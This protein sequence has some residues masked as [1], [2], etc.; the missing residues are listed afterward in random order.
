MSA[1][2]YFP[3]LLFASLALLTAAATAQSDFAVVLLPDTQ[4][5]SESYANVFNGQTQWIVA[6]A[7]A[8]K[9]QMVLGLGDVVNTPGQT[10]EWQNADAAIRVLENAGIPTYIAIGN[11]DYANANAST[12]SATTFNQYFGPARY[13]GKSWY[14]G[15]YPAGSNENFYG[16]LTLG[17]EAYLVLVL[18]YV[19]RTAALN[20]AKTVLDA[21]SGKKVIV[22]EH[23]F[24]HS[25]GTRTDVCD[26]GDMNSDNNGE[27]QWMSLLRNY[28]NIVM[29]VNG[30][31]T[32]GGGHGWRKDLGVKGNIVNQM[33]SDYQDYPNGGDGWLRILK[34]HPLSKQIS[35][36]TYSPFLNSNMTG[37]LDQ[38]TLNYGTPAPV[39]GTATVSGRVR[40]A[41]IGSTQDCQPV[42]AATVTTSGVTKLTDTNGAY[43]MSL[44][45]P[46]SY[47]VSSYLS[48]WNVQT[49]TVNAWTN[50]PAD[51]EFFLTPKRGT[52]A[53]FVKNTSGAGVA[54]A[55][56]N[57]TGGMVN[58]NRTVKTDST[59]HYTTGL[60]S[61]GNYTATA[62]MTGH[63]TQK[64][65]TSVANN[66]TTT[67][68][69]SNF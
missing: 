67:L 3:A 40:M 4:N 63:T 29:V 65:A 1:R 61:I 41:R 30:H 54:G 69:F 21:S 6:N 13:S 20:W 50:Y 59:G 39:S 19:P 26:T 11:H 38:F 34:F 46:A 56:I 16:S 35:V 62:S 33:L 68:S 28:S 37:P 22:V 14:T 60:I 44:T 57:V 24:M 7:S 64:K 49:Q 43:S 9:I 27:A 10:Y 51:L 17:G 48:N 31:L 47:S 52:V 8:L 5:Y 15:S 36:S 18:E 58:F 55:S 42:A 66:T 32:T 25:D 53:G 12:R 23:S 45:A 2:H